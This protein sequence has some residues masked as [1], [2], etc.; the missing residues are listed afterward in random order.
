MAGI[1]NVKIIKHVNTKSNV[2]H[3]YLTFLY[4]F[5]EVRTLLQESTLG[6]VVTHIAVLDCFNPKLVS[7]VTSENADVARKMRESS[8]V[9]I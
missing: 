4:A 6:T 9:A 7:W 3:L 5:V 2:Y 8:S 1:S